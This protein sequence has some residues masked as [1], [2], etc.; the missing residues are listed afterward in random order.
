MS[1]GQKGKWGITLA[2]LIVVAVLLVAGW[3]HRSQPQEFAASLSSPA[4]APHVSEKA[5]IRVPRGATSAAKVSTHAPTADPS[6]N[7]DVCGIQKVR[8]AGADAEDVNGGV[9]EATRE[10]HDRWNAALL[11]SPDTRARAVGLLLQRFESLREDSAV[12]AEE[13]RDELVQLAAGGNDPALYAIAVGLCQTNGVSAAVTTGAC[14]RISL[15]EWARTD[16]SNAMPWIAV[17][18]AARASGDFQAE[19]AAFTRAAQ[20]HSLRSPGESMFQFGLQEVPRDAAP[21]EKASLSFELIGHEVASIGPELSEV[22]RYCSADAV[23]QTQIRKDCNAVAELL[24]GPESTLLYFSLG[25]K[26]G[27]RVGWPAERVRQLSDEKEELLRIGASN[28][29]LPGSC[30]AI[31]RINTFLDERA[32]LGELAALRELRDQR[33]PSGGPVSY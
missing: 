14:Q 30:A 16:P 1:G 15:T 7:A 21:A 29:L 3:L 28:E 32:R 23:K 18:Q 13:S 2:A 6:S 22:M 9:I 12:Q 24:V 8:P 33:E 17:A 19:A 25:A 11:D 26:L 31:S 10:T 20:A 27:E 5:R 4:P